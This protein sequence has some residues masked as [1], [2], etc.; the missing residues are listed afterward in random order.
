MVGVA[1]GVHGLLGTVW[2]KANPAVSITDVKKECTKMLNTQGEK[3]VT[4]VNQKMK[5]VAKCVNQ[6]RGDV[7]KLWSGLIHF[8][9]LSDEGQVQRGYAGII[10]QLSGG[11]KDMDL[12][13]NAIDRNLGH[14]G[15]INNYQK[16]VEKEPGA[17]PELQKLLPVAHAWMKVCEKLSL[18]FIAMLKEK[19][20]FTETYIETVNIDVAQGFAS[21][22]QVITRYHSGITSYYHSALN[23]RNF[24]YLMKVHREKA[25]K[26]FPSRQPRKGHKWHSRNRAFCR[27]QGTNRAD[28]HRY[29]TNWGVWETTDSFENCV[30]TGGWYSFSGSRTDLYS[31][32]DMDARRRRSYHGCYG[33]ECGGRSHRSY[34]GRSGRLLEKDSGTK[35]SEKEEE[36]LRVD[37]EKFD[38]V[39]GLSTTTE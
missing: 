19:I 5:E 39:E 23:Y 34:R 21:F 14:C 12:I 4:L 24:L 20:P 6:L 32:S 3:I 29:T 27:R 9:L 35:I 16:W 2:G 8:N 15:A 36:H 17:K 37:D 11:T 28:N 38:E 25:A 1:G 31:K 33:R 22:M 18:M 7:Q 30:T 26:R 10:M 13:A